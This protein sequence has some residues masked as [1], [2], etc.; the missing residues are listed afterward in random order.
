MSNMQQHLLIDGDDT[1]WENNIYFE[2]AIEA[3]IDFLNHS[4]LKP[5]EVRA[6]LDEM[7]LSHGYGSANFARSLQATYRHLAE[8]DIS[9]EDLAHAKSLGTQILHHPMQVMDGVQETLAYLAQRH[10]LILLT[11]G[12]QDE[13]QLKVESSG[14]ES[15]FR[16]IIIVQEKD[17]ATYERLTTEFQFDRATTWMIGNAPRS[18]INPA[19]KAGLNAVFIPHPHTW[20]LEQQEVRHEGQGRLLTLNTFAD[21]RAHF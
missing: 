8:R 2:Q 1:L 14:L 6:V 3:F 7:E 15:Y 16:H 13:Q 18:D 17:V 19:L 5:R 4:S 20:G 10:T 21:L 9:D 11:K 12:D